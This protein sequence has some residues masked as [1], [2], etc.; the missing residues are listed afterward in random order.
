MLLRV[1]RARGVAEGRS[2]AAVALVDQL[3][4]RELRTAL[5]PVAPRDL[6]QVLRERL[7]QPVGERL[8][9]D[10]AVVVVLRLVAS[11]E[12]LG[13]EAGGDRERSDEVAL[14]G[15]V[16]G[17]AAVLTPVSVRRLL[18]QKVETSNDVAWSSVV[19]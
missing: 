17:K 5:V 14:G 10:R 13:A 2:D 11:G 6:V 4:V 16:V 19:T 12:L 18:A 3:F 7:R 8:D 1:V 9:H 15:D